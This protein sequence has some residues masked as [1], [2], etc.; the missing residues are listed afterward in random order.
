MSFL[1]VDLSYYTFTRLE[2]YCICRPFL[3]FV[4]H[5][6]C[7]LI[8]ATKLHIWVQK[9][10][11]VI[12]ETLWGQI[13]C[14]DKREWIFSTWNIPKPKNFKLYAYLYVFFFFPRRIFDEICTF[15]IVGFH[16]TASYAI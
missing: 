1:G 8:D 10:S 7:V 11:H 16:V 9:A 15:I 2:I 13:L 6:L 12:K 5:R 14:H 4:S 3:F